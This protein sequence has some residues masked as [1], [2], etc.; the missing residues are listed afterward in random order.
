MF[1]K[2]K[3]NKSCGLYCSCGCEDGVVLHVERDEDFECFISLVSDMYNI[4]QLTWLERFKAK[5]KRI[6]KII[7]NKEHYY[8]DICITEDDIAEFKEFV[9]NI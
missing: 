4:S 6:W 1:M 8:F 3:D 2:S 5:C 9:A 7:T